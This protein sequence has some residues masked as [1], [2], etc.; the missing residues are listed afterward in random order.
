MD[1]FRAL[2][3]VNR[4]REYRLDPLQPAGQHPADAALAIAGGE[5][6]A[7]GGAGLGVGELHRDLEGN[8][9]IPVHELERVVVAGDQY[10]AAF[11][12][13]GAVIRLVD[14]SGPRQRLLD[15]LIERFDAVV[16]GAQR[17][18]Q[19]ELGVGLEDGRGPA[20]P[21]ASLG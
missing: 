11:V 19:L 9:D 12:P 15:A 8:A 4:H 3:L 5:G 21:L 10:R 14:Q 16:A 7:Q 1:E 13:V 18:Q 20:V 17:R 6:H 2:G